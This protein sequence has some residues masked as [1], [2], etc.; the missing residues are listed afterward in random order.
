MKLFDTDFL[1]MHLRF[2]ELKAKFE[3][4][5]IFFT[6]YGY[7]DNVDE[8]LTGCLSN[9]PNIFNIDMLDKTYEILGELGCK[10]FK[11]ILDFYDN[12]ITCQG[13]Y[14]KNVDGYLQYR[15]SDLVIGCNLIFNHSEN[16]QDLVNYFKNNF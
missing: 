5:E 12:K 11:T 13:F 15:I 9:M 7:V 8:Y 6:D 2:S 14:F 16:K 1:F 3:K 10:R 4:G